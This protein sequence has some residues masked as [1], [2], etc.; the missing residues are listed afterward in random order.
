MAEIEPFKSTFLVPAWRRSGVFLAWWLILLV[1]SAFMYRPFC[2]YLCPLGAGLALFGSFRVSGPRRRRFCSS[3]KICTNACEPRAFR[4]DG[5]I[6]PRECLSCM[7]CE[8]TYRDK[9]VCP[10]LVG[11]AHLETVQVLSP[12]QRRKRSRLALDLKDL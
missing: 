2:R 6:D 7:E 11:V 12:A 4:P 9:A 8:A 3:C 1:A 10:P 5:T